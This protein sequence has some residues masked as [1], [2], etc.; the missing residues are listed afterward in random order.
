M[1]EGNFKYGQY[2]GEGILYDKSGRILHQGEFDHG[3]I[4]N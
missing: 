3:S 2:S 1:Y 4:K